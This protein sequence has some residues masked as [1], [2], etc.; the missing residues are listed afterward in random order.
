MGR[1]IERGKG[2][3]LLGSWTRVVVVD[4]W[5]CDGCARR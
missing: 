2:N 3:Y 5:K 1:G 4:D